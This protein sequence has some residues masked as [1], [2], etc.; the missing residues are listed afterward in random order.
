MVL[1][2]VIE[3]LFQQ[4]TFGVAHVNHNLREA[5]DDEAAF[6]KDYCQTRGIP[7]YERVWQDPPQ[8]ASKRPLESS[9]IIFCRNDDSSE[10]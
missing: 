5:S 9:A 8:M 1:L 10:L 4:G 3:E 6:L 7:Y 2:H